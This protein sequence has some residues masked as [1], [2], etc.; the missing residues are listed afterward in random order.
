MRPDR[1]FRP[2]RIGIIL[3]GTGQ[4]RILTYLVRGVGGLARRVGN[5]S[6][7]TLLTGQSIW[8]KAPFF[9]VEKPLFHK[10]TLSIWRGWNFFWGGWNFSGGVGIF[11][12]GVGIFFWGVGADIWGVEPP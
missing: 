12:G 5:I 2:N 1:K 9:F 3:T 10:N 8:G 4:G 11:S 7:L 6:P